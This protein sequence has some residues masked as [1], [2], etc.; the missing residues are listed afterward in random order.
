MSKKIATPLQ[1]LLDELRL[2]HDVAFCADRV[3]ELTEMNPSLL[4]QEPWVEAMS[5]LNIS[6]MRY[7]EHCGDLVEADPRDPHPNLTIVKSDTKH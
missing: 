5:D 1:P 2:L 4:G 3:L 6:M 7:A